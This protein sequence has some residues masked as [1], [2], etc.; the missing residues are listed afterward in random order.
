[1]GVAQGDRGTLVF[2]WSGGAESSRLEFR[3]ERPGTGT[4]VQERCRGN[5]WEK[6]VQL[7]RGLQV[8]KIK[9]HSIKKKIRDRK[10][11]S[12]RAMKR[13]RAMKSPKSRGVR[14]V[15]SWVRHSGNRGYSAG[16]KGWDGR[17]GGL[18]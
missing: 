7:V 14:G 2:R 8:K 3:T 10:R 4:L 11:K 6:V 16:L 13:R 5:S 17:Y 12:K 15:S 18:N 1:M 9:G